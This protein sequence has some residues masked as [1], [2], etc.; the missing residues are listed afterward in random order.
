MKTKL[1]M[2]YFETIQATN[3]FFLKTFVTKNFKEVAENKCNLKMI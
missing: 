1:K 3:E 2:C